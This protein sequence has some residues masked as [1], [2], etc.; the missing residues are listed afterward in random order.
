MSNMASYND[1]EALW[2]LASYTPANARNIAPS[3]NINSLGF[4][5]SSGFSEVVLSDKSWTV[6]T[7]TTGR[8]NIFLNSL[9]MGDVISISNTESL[10]GASAHIFPLGGHTYRWG[11]IFP[12]SRLDEV[13][14][15]RT[16]GKEMSLHI[17]TMSQVRG[18]QFMANGAV[19]AHTIDAWDSGDFTDVRNMPGTRVDGL[20]N[21]VNVVLA[22]VPKVTAWLEPRAA[23]LDVNEVMTTGFDEGYANYRFMML[24]AVAAFEFGGYGEYTYDP[25]LFRMRPIPIAQNTSRGDTSYSD[26]CNGAKIFHLPRTSPILHDGPLPAASAIFVQDLE[27]KAVIHIPTIYKDDGTA[28]STTDFGTVVATTLVEII[29]DVKGQNTAPTT[30]HARPT[31]SK[32]ERRRQ[33]METTALETH[34]STAGTWISENWRDVARKALQGTGIVAG[35]AG[36]IV[37][38]ASE[39]G[40]A[41]DIGAS[42]L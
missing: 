29:V 32:N 14:A 30:V 11:T 16:I 12:G 23:M 19:P 34:L 9:L 15:Y 13:I 8:F 4:P 6:K 27:T 41:A 33:V 1:R 10:V 22:H 21:M 42:F 35:L 3:G 18:G 26:I 17:T 20:G 2:S 37:P 31:A 28:A 7:D 5:N 24:D 36:G 39:V 25:E 40:V 38:L